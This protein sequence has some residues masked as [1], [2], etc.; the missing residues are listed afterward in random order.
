MPFKWE[1]GFSTGI[2]EID[3]QHKLFI[4]LINRLVDSVERNDPAA[5]VEIKFEKLINYTAFHFG[6]EE[7]YMHSF[8]YAGYEEHKIEHNVI[9]QKLIKCQAEFVE[10]KSAGSGQDRK[11]LIL[12]TKF[13]YEWLK[14][15]MAIVDKKYVA[16][17]KSKGL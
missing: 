13:L 8:K 5:S 11:P 12:L 9:F 3:D 14:E 16:L 4:K 7:D 10:S 6:T 15:H 2:S 17:F 1:D